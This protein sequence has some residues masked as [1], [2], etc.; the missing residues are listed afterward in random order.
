MISRHELTSLSTTAAFS[1][2]VKLRLLIILGFLQRIIVAV[3]FLKCSPTQMKREHE[4]NPVGCSVLAHIQQGG[5]PTENL[6][7]L[8]SL[9]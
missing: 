9:K 7:P 4:L 6:A 1:G 2:K 8:S 3:F 5:R